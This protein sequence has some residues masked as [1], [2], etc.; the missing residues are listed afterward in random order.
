[1]NKF[2]LVFCLLL[3]M[4]FSQEQISIN[5]ESLYDLLINVFKGMSATDE[6]RCANIFVENKTKMVKVINTIIEDIK[7]G[8]DFSSCLAILSFELISIDNFLNDCRLI[9]IMP[10]INTLFCEDGI[11]LLGNRIANNSKTIFNLINEM[12]SVIELPDK[13]KILGQ[14]L[15]IILDFYVQ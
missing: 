9:S 4:D 7:A 13:L 15:R 10:V 6:C 12:K 8:Q 11:K 2:A 14:I 1:M 5:I 3:I